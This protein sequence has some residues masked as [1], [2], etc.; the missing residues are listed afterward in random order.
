MI[1]DK[2]KQ[3]TSV[4]EKGKIWDEKD[5]IERAKEDPAAF[6]PLYDRYY[7]Q[8]FKFIFYRIS[9]EDQASDLCSAVFLKA[10]LKIKTYED[11]GFSF[12]A[13]LYKI[14]CNE[15][16]QF[17]R[18]YKQQ[19]AV[20]ISQEFM[21]GLYP[22][23]KEPDDILLAKLQQAIQELDYQEVQLIELKYWEKRSYKEIAY[24]MSMS[25]ANAKTKMHRIYKKLEK[26][27]KKYLP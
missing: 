8:I 1:F 4:L 6:Q 14:A 3:K 23:E 15:T 10:L 17:F 21:E 26:R 25:V 13:W 5:W 18:Q 16:L 7:E 12:G 24:I 20:M 2:E 11:K 27:L 22:S 19:R 9:D